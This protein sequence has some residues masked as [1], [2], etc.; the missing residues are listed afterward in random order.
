MPRFSNLKISAKILALLGLLAVVSI[1]ATVFATGRMRTIDDTYG[2]LID[3]PGKANLAIARANRNL[4]YINRSIY[5]LLTEVSEAGNKQAVQE[6]TETEGFFDK[7]IKVAMRGMPN[8]A[9]DI[10]HVADNY[11][12][13]MAG[14]CAE[15][16]RLGQSLSE[17]GKRQAGVQMREKCDPALHGL[18][19]EISALTNK[20]IK[21]NDAASD[22]ALAVTNQT[23]KNTYAAV[24]GG[25]AVVLVLAAYIARVGISSPIRTIARALEA[26][27]GGRFDTAIHGA[28]RKD[29]VGDIAKAAL[30]FRDAMRQNVEASAERD[31]MREMSEAETV[32]ALRAAADTIERETIVVTERSAQTS[33]VLVTRTNTLAASAERMLS[34][35]GS[36]S[37]ASETAL[38]R[39]ELVA[40][41][42]EE[43]SASAREIA[44]QI[45]GTAAEI[46]SAARAGE[47]ARQ[48]IDQLATAVGQI[49]AV[50]RLIGDIAGRT[51]LLALNATIEAARA[52][53]AGRGFAVVASEVK[54]L[55]SQTAN[56]TQEIARNAGAIQ[57]ATQ[58]AV[59]VVSEMIERVTQ[60]ERITA[61]VA[62]AAEQ[63]TAATG[64]IARNVA[65][66]AEAMRE[67]A[68]Q[69]GMVSQ[70]THTTGAAV[71]EMRGLAADVGARIAELRGVM[72][73]IVRTSSDAADRR[74]SERVPIEGPATLVLDGRGLPAT[75]VDLSLGG[76]RVRVDELLENG[77]K[78]VLRLPNLPD[79]P[80]ELRKGGDDVRMRF[81]WEPDD[82]PVALRRLMEQS[83]AA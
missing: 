51:N 54:A 28:G 41:A 50:A 32:A 12:A 72:V 40:A 8:E 49:G 20:I 1:G 73:R 76:A 38:R 64:E 37:E 29:E 36:V 47:R 75:C 69:M 61:S 46:A 21:L 35:V 74:Q 44:S 23:I 4:V 77:A 13:A 19:D 16:I 31:R 63:Q 56:S 57:Q 48:M 30:V 22:A 9:P 26:L 45:G 59:R 10:R 62:A 43:L 79:L 52:G 17:D 83:A 71:G 3:G 42:S 81:A 67:V 24:L 82:A 58:D 27:A 80:G 60:I 39:S 65:G 18:M 33:A 53:E 11:R 2:D 68:G 55:A 34:S 78:V 66:T 5:R 6:L 15:T 7:Q 25:L 14:P 70:E